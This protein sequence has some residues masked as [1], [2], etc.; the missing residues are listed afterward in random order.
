M[1]NILI[2]SPREVNPTMGG[3]ERVSDALAR[4]LMNEGY[5]VVF[6]SEEHS[7]TEDYIP[8]SIQYFVDNNK[9]KRLS[10]LLD[11]V[12]KYNINVV[13]NQTGGQVALL[14][15]LPRSVKI[16]SVM[17]DSK[18][19]MYNNLKLCWLRKLRW[20]ILTQRQLRRLYCG[21]DK[22]VLFSEKF[23]PE[24]QFFYCDEDK[25]KFEIIPNFNSYTTVSN[26]E[27]KNKTVLFVGRLSFGHKRPDYLLNIWARIC[28]KH[29]DWNLQIVGDGDYAEKAKS[30]ASQLN[31]IN[32]SFEG[33]QNPLPYYQKAS[34]FCLT[35]AFESFGMVLTEAMQCGVVPLAFNSYSTASEIISDGVDGF[36]IEPFNLEAYAE[37]L[38]RLMTYEDLR[39]KM[40]VKALNN[41]Q[42]YSHEKIGQ[43]WL[44]LIEHKL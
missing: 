19:A 23:I 42:K 29:P 8:S 41:V 3:I 10:Q 9:A 27:Y 33:Q 22:V 17:H 34:I 30:L 40:S 12:K 39:S 4:L 25:S 31:L 37:K 16:I 2:I 14:G 20:K 38:D 21:S 24:Y 36:L 43:K 26:I 35:S 6:L 28:R 1:K 5:S 7:S 44:E 13:V 11:I 18:Y 32:Y 15:Q